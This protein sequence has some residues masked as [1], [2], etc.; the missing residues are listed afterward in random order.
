[1]NNCKFLTIGLS[2]C[3]LI[4][5]TT[6]PTN[7]NDEK[8]SASK[9]QA[10]ES[11]AKSEVT[12]EYQ[13]PNYAMFSGIEYG[14]NEVDINELSKEIELVCLNKDAGIELPSKAYVFRTETSDDKKTRLFF[15]LKNASSKDWNKVLMRKQ[16]YY[17]S[18]GNVLHSNDDMYSA[19]AGVAR[20]N[21][22][23]EKCYSNNLTAG[24]TG[25]FTSLSNDG[26]F[27]KLA[28]VEF[29]ISY[30]TDATSESDMQIVPYNVVIDGRKI[31]VFFENKGTR[32]TRF[33]G[34]RLHAVLF[35]DDRPVANIML[36]SNIKPEDGNLEPGMKGEAT[37]ALTVLPKYRGF[38]NR[39]YVYAYVKE[40][41]AR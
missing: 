19:I 7:K 28:K 13:G 32:A 21:D 10:E 38:A 40:A 36:S 4:S 37:G 34:N 3:V 41:N 8:L 33:I 25:Y 2:L 30:A 16:Y 39:I 26:L 22:K 35:N 15:P 29:D 31:T 1:M 14:S 23:L 27:H 20:K 18:E 24:V 9:V 5:C 6:K 11:E 12:I 17:D